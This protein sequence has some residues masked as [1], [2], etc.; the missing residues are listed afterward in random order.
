MGL[1]LGAGLLAIAHMCHC[2]FGCTE[3]YQAAHSRGEG[4]D[5]E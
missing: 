5:H 1:D 4:K 3:E 2:R